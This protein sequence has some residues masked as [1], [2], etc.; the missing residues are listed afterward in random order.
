MKE[1]TK[2]AEGL[3]HVVSEPGDATRYDYFVYRDYDSFSFMPCKSTF[4]FPQSLC[5]FDV[6]Q[7]E[8]V[9]DFVDIAKT[10][11]CNP[12]TVLECVRTMRELIVQ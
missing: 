3:Y 7:S 4:S 2:I 9:K 5:I 6:P 10:F 1:Y 8:D 12:H 11:R